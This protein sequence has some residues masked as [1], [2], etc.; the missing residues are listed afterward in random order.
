MVFAS[1]Q[2]F[3][4]T[5]KIEFDPAKVPGPWIER[6][7]VV[8]GAA[9]TA[10]NPFFIIWWA[11]VGALLITE[12][13]TLGAFA[14]VLGIFAAHIWM[15]YA[16]LGGTATLVGRGKLVLGKWYHVVLVAFGVAM[17]YFGTSFILSSI[18]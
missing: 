3:Q 5:K 7:G 18:V 10:L 2:L 12:A 14:G 6:N 8:I 13:R 9:F 4:A 15:D 17:I 11:T 16:W 1:L